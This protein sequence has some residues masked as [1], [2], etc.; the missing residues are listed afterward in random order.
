MTNRCDC[1]VAGLGAAGS[2]A[3]Y[4][5]AVRG[6]RV[7]GLDAHTPPHAHGS[8]HGETRMIREA[9]FEDPCYVPLVRRAYSLWHALAAESKTTLIEETGGVFAGGDDGEMVPGIFNAGQTHD[10]AVVELTPEERARRY[11]W[12]R[13][14]G[15]MRILTEP[16]AGFLYPERCIT[17]HLDGAI[18]RG[19]VVH[20]G[21]ALL[22]WSA[23]GGGID[24]ET[25][26]GRFSAN[27]LILATGAWMTGPLAAAGVVAAVARQPLYWFR[28]ADA[29]AV[30]AMPVWAVEF[31][32][33][34]L[35]YG[36]PDRGR[37]LKVAIHDP[38]TPTTVETID[39]TVHDEEI[40]TIRALTAR[41]LP[42]VFGDLLDTATCMY[43]N[44]PDG[45]FVI[46]T[47]P[48]H[49]NVLLVSACSGHG[50]KFAS[51]TGEA[52][53]H[54]MLDGAPPLDLAAFSLGRF[55]RG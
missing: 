38:G 53:A 12:L 25:A 40:A 44:T 30:R 17:A 7:T 8:S 41:Y 5:L 39:R 32:K 16:R 50:F 11:P 10:I 52:A 3:L 23:D 6:A 9:Y 54:W 22:G 36:F 47:H 55:R 34:R 18:A 33:G 49:P 20:A 24:V 43:T 28:A 26:G 51:A 31:E 4:H 37:G 48:A 2:A 45:H 13:P 27:R 1:I 14:G 19:A 15:D 29:K 21:T 46:D 42:G 35:L